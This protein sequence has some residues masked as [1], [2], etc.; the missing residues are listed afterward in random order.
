MLKTHL[1][2]LQTS[3]SRFANAAVF[4]TPEIDPSTKHIKGWKSITYQEFYRDVE[5]FAKHWTRTLRGN[6]IP[7][8]SV[9]GVWY[10][11]S[12]MD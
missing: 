12:C 9:V 1:S 6:G 11:F 2:I 10:V 5:T 4:K 7:Q 3:A 8:R